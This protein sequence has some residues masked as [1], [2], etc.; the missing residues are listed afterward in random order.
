MKFYHLSHDDSMDFIFPR[1]PVSRALYE[2]SFIPRVCFAPSINLCL[3]AK[4]PYSP[5]VFVVYIVD[6][7][8][9]HP[10]FPTETQ[11]PD[12]ERTKE[13]W[14]LTPVDVKKV[15]II[16]VLSE[17]LIKS[18]QPDISADVL[19]YKWRWLHSN[20]KILKLETKRWKVDGSIYDKR[21][22]ITAKQCKL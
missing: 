21:M 11:V 4:E 16:K 2:E 7:P 10:Y 5:D 20:F 14:S 9:F 12:V 6:D 13:V 1:V 3:T 19:V 18:K 8:E 15:G 22:K 17:K